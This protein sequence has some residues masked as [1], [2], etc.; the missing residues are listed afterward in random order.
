MKIWVQWWSIA[1]QFRPCFSR[2]KTFMWFI[3]VL[4]GFSTRNDLAGVSSIIRSLGLDAFH[5][6]RLLD[7]FH[8]S[9]IK[10]DM[11][12]KKWLSIV[13]KLGLVHEVNGRVILLGDGIK[14]PKEGR[15]MPAVK[16]LHQESESNTKP[17]YI[18]GHSCQAISLLL[19]TASYFFAVPIICRIHEGII[20]SNRDTRTQ[21]DKLISMINCLEIDRQ[22]YLV[23]D[24]YYSNKKIV[25]GLL[26]A[27]QHL[28]TRVKKN[29][30][31]YLLPEDDGTVR[32][33]RK[34]T[35]GEKIKLI[36]IFKDLAKMTISVVSIYNEGPKEI[37]YRSID[38]L[39]RPVGR[40]VRFVWVIH[41]TKGRAIFMSTD[42]SLD[43][44]QIIK[45]Y[46]LRFKIEVS[47]KQAI[48]SV[49]AY[50][51]HFW[52]MSMH[53]I[54]RKS[55]NQYLHRE[56]QT[57]RD[58]IMRK[59]FAY[60]THIQIGLIAQGLLQVI[61]MIATQ[62]VW[63]NF[64]SWIR[65]IRPGILPSEKIVMTALRNT[66]PKFLNGTTTEVNIEKFI[67]EKVDLG[68]SEGQR[69]VM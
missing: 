8:S 39:W 69:M 5:Y 13:L 41:P 63:E 56:T 64:G 60:H 58:L 9:A 19:T 30:V 68:R 2:H 44:L 48:N 25:L 23:A 14:I 20:K 27:G 62:L 29:A 61:S 11:L 6:D 21:M 17:E 31:A 22:F 45:M 15:K 51:Y 59:I 38:L 26:K 36:E 35:Y 46:S 55:G 24:A 54:K 67:L 57:Y 53:K 32:R 10:L 7:F 16:S 1:K 65:T 33:G 18:M 28:I 66:L 12:S 47:F 52:M 4:I 3:L 50:A 37:Y 43:P 49:G 40:I 34:R 42:L